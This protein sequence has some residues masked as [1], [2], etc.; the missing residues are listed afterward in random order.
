M[1]IITGANSSFYLSLRQLLNNIKHFVRPCDKVYCVDLGLTSKQYNFLKSRKYESKF[2]FEL[3]QIPPEV[4]KQYPPHV[5][6]LESL[7]NFKE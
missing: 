5:L 4:V 1:I 3:V 2:N 7:F 6:Y